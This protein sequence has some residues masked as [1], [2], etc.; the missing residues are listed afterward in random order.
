MWG[1]KPLL[2]IICL[3][4]LTVGANVML[5]LG[6]MVAPSQRVYSGFSAGNRLPAWSSPLIAG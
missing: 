4:A 2:G 6:A 3:I 5:K 1:L